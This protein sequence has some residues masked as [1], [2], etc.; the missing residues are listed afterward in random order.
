MNIEI[1]NI[2]QKQSK[3]VSM[4]SLGKGIHHQKFLPT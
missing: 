1:K 4:V 2:Q 3:G